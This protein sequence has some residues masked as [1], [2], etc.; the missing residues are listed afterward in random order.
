MRQKGTDGKHSFVGLLLHL[1]KD[2][3]APLPPCT[4]FLWVNKMVESNNW[5]SDMNSYYPVLPC[6]Y[7]DPRQAPLHLQYAVFSGPLKLME[8]VAT[9]VGWF[10]TKGFPRMARMLVGREKFKV[11]NRIL[12]EGHRRHHTRNPRRRHFGRRTHKTKA[13]YGR[14]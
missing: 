6:P 5:S 14:K 8:H 2:A 9:E 4:P 1:I 10:F 12:R 7:A 13:Y 3:V 11:N